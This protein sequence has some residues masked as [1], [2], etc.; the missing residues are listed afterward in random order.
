MQNKETF[1]I[2]S[3]IMTFNIIAFADRK[4]RK[5]LT[6]AACIKGVKIN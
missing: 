3:E 4:K 2:K 6:K 5:K 1:E